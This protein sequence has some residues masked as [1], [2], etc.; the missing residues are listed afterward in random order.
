MSAQ[1]AESLPRKDKVM[2][3]DLFTDEEIKKAIEKVTAQ[4]DSQ[5]ML[6]VLRSVQQTGSLRNSSGL[7]PQTL[8]ILQRLANFGLVDPGYSGPIDG[9]PFLWVINSNGERVLRYLTGIRAGP[10]YEIP[11]T[12]LAAWLEQQG[13]DRW[14]NVDGDPL[15]TGRM[16]FPCPAEELAD[17]LRKVNRA[18]LVQAKSDDTGA[19]GQVIDAAMLEKVVGRFGENVQVPGVLPAVLPAGGANRVLYLCWKRSAHEWLLAEDRIT[20]EQNRA[21]EAART[22]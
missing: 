13:K 21:D 1:R 22:R 19:R 4:A 17:E 20:T 11:S 12:E 2:P 16:S 10:H 14:W 8:D 18:L 3:A 5:A 6:S 15:L 9:P 7:D